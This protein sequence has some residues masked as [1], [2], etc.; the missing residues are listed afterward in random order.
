MSAE[1][2]LVLYKSMGCGHCTEL[3]KIWDT[4]P[5]KDGASI[6]TE[7][8]KVYPKLRF[9]VVTAKDNTGRFDENTI[10]KDLIRYGLWFPMILLIPGRLWDEAMSKL[11]PKNDVKLIEGVQI[12]N[13]IYADN[14]PQYV[15]K[16]NMKKPE[17]FG[18]WLKHVLENEEFKRVQNGGSGQTTSPNSIVPVVQTPSQPIQPLISSIVRP[19]NTTTSYVG[20]GSVDRK[21]GTEDICGMRIISR[22]R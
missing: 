20:A 13:G 15:Q 21:Q 17:E 3:T 5:N 4:P 6:T 16:Y 22:P 2:V 7:L 11:G 1:P 12:M 18:K 9:M 8:K 14:K 19:G 10:P